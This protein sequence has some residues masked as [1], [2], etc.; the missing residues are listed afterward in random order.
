MSYLKEPNNVPISI[1]IL[2]E[3]EYH[4]SYLLSDI[5]KNNT[6]KRRAFSEKC[7][8][9]IFRPVRILNEREANP[10]IGEIIPEIIFNKSARSPTTL[11]QNERWS[12]KN[13]TNKITI[14]SMK[15]L[16]MPFM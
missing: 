15:S 10:T 2:Y 4:N 13:N 6:K 9:K 5:I 14:V 3:Q 16:P 12:K 7:T 8:T 1:S 11:I